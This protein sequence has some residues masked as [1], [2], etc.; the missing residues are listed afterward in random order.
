MRQPARESGAITRDVQTDRSQG[1][2]DRSADPAVR[3]TARIRHPTPILRG[4]RYAPASRPISRP[5]RFPVTLPETLVPL[6]GSLPSSFG[7][8]RAPT[9]RLSFSRSRAHHR[10]SGA[11]AAA[12]S[13]RIS[14][15]SVFVPVSV[16]VPDGGRRSNRRTNQAGGSN[17]RWLLC[18][19]G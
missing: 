12:N 3:P 4:P 7:S 17:G 14:A 18:R 19:G 11:A 2:W 5:F 10:T 9:T 15:A 13:F 8:W 16:S 6:R 1:R